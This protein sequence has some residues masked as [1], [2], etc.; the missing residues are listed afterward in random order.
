VRTRGKR[1]TRDLLTPPSLTLQKERWEK[2]QA[3]SAPP[4]SALVHVPEAAL[5]AAEA[6]L[7]TSQEGD[8]ATSVV[9]RGNQ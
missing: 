3:A 7:N 2:E 5:A 9:Y 1:R 4:V 6:E 8:E